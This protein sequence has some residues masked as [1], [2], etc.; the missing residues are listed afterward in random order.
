M[1]IKKMATDVLDEVI[2]WRRDLHQIPE[3]GTEL[4][5]TSKYVT[6]R[7]DEMGISYEKGVGLEHAIVG[8]IN[9]EK[10]EGKTIALRADMD[11]LPVEEETGLPFASTNG[12]MHAC[13]HD[14][15]T[16][17]LLGAAKIL[18][19]MKDKFAGKVVLLFQPAEE[20]SGGAEPMV[21]AGCLEG[22]DAVMGL[23]I[24]NITS[25]GE[26]GMAMFSKDSIMACLDRWAMDV[27]GVGS[28]G[29]YPHNSRDPI[30]MTSNIVSSIQ[31]IISRELNP[32][33]PGVITVGKMQGG[34]TYNVIPNQVELEG[35]ARSV[36]QE[37]REF[38]ARRIG[39][40]GEQVA[41]AS[42]G[43][44]E[45]DYT[46]GAPPVINDAEFTEVAMESA[47]KV[48]GEENVKELDNPVM[49]GEDFAYYL[50]E[51]P[52]SFIFLYNPREVDG[53]VYPHH[54]SKFDIDEQYFD[55]GISLFV[56]TTLDFLNK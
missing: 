11:A 22:V 3:L 54:N 28:H 10:G 38:I 35:T 29:A 30:V 56:Q 48:L 52:G 7:L 20:I 55:N 36:N 14:G 15:H 37:T 31:T 41:E 1:D 49:G 24:G 42:R 34:S 9:G 13:G 6:E 39:E 12:N 4:P 17:I 43:E 25:E 46:F 33:E 51:V 44:V 8:V 16:S 26:P 23:H 53:E 21:E 40:I 50:N 18:N 5:K 45:Y 19:D 27:K 47:R 2:G 32:V